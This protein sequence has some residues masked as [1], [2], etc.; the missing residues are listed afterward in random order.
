MLYIDSRTNKITMTQGDNASIEVVL[1]ERELFRDD[2]ITMTV[3]DKNENI[4][5]SKTAENGI[6]E[7]EPADTENLNRNSL[8]FYDIQL[9]TFGG[10]VYTIVED[11]LFTVKREVT[12]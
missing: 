8:Y 12:A 2:I 3:R 10:K 4:V 1:N 11:A 6:I 5:L 7:I 9:T